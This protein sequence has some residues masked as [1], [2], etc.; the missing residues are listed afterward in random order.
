[1]DNGIDPQQYLLAVTHG[2]RVESAGVDY[3]R[4][5][6]VAAKYDHQIAHHRRFALLVK[7]DDVALRQPFECHF[8]HSD[9]AVDDTRAGGDD[10]VGLLSA[11]HGLGDLWRVG[12]MAD[13]HLDDLH[14]GNGD[15]LGH[16]CGQLAGD[17]VGRAAQRQAVVC[18]VVVGMGGRNVPQ[19][20]LGLDT[21]EV[22]VVVHGV[23]STRG[24]GNLP[25]DNGSDLHGIAVS[26][27]DLQV[28]RLEVPDPNGHV[29]PVGE[30][31]DPGQAGTTHGPDVAAEK[32][33]DP[34]LAG[35]HDDEG[36]QDDHAHHAHHDGDVLDGVLDEQDRCG[37]AGGDHEDA[38]PAV[39]RP[40]LPLLDHDAGPRGADRSRFGFA[41]RLDCL[42][43]AH[44]P[45][46]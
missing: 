37:D 6:L 31:Q 5:W 30:G 17:A 46:L 38:E 7:L 35:L 23:K 24:I 34:G 1:M 27:V 2:S 26:V 28:V 11:Q 39:D 10:C 12:Q 21:H 25:D 3:R 15:A 36:G 8:N 16:L 43:L 13:A 4:S 14:S 9:R 40:R 19:C 29:P 42:A 20:R 32:P 44:G 22:E 18:G 45:S 33:H 41:V